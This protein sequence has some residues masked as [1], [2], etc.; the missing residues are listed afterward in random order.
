MQRGGN[1]DT[2]ERQVESIRK[3]MPNAGLRTSFIIG[4]PGETEED[5]NEVLTFVRNVAFDS[6]GA[7]L[8]SDEDGTGAFDLDRK[9]PRRTAIR[10]RNQLM[11]TQSGISKRKL[12]SMVGRRVEVLLEGVSDESE[13]LLKGRMETQAPDIDGHV[14]INDLGDL[15]DAG[16][17]APR[18]GHFYPVEITESLEYDLLGCIV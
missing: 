16:G 12:R 11:K 3:L 9:V 5:F 6:V 17:A 1:R 10:R 2:Y 8:Y 4:F 14:L 13:L 7:F 18:V 15:G